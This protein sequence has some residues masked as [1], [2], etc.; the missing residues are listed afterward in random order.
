MLGAILEPPVRT[1]DSPNSKL[2]ISSAVNTPISLAIVVASSTPK[3]NTII[4]PNVQVDLVN[5]LIGS[6]SG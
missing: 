4:V 1:V 6:R 2:M 5:E 3:R